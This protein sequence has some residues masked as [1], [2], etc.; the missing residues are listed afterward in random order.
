MY[1]M[2]YEGQN[3]LAFGRTSQ[4]DFKN[5]LSL[6]LGEGQ[7]EKKAQSITSPSNHQPAI[8]TI[9]QSVMMLLPHQEEPWK[10]MVEDQ[11]HTTILQIL[12]NILLG[13]PNK[14]QEESHQYYT[15][16]CPRSYDLS[17]LPLTSL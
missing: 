5:Q 10:F 7:V 11:I 14:H 17:F 2:H 9:S 8:E 12:N 6:S 4:Y 1:H 13:T 3:Q 15:T 16:S